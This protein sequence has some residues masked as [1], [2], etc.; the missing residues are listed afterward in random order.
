MAGVRL[1]TFANSVRQLLMTT[2]DKI[3]G[4]CQLVI[5]TVIFTINQF[6]VWSCQLN[7]VYALT[8]RAKSGT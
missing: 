8:G 1:R 6:L 7:V 4:Y 5:A 3:S 2:E